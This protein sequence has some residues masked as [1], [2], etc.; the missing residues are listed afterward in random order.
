MLPLVLALALTPSP[1]PALPSV[2]GLRRPMPVAAD[3][4]E[5][6]RWSLTELGQAVVVVE[7][8]YA[9]PLPKVAT[10][11]RFLDGNLRLFSVRGINP[12]DIPAAPWMDTGTIR[13][14][15]NVVQKTYPIGW[16]Y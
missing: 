14:G 7:G 8:E 3:V 13:S 2:A 6:V 5:Y 16:G 15:G 12:A 11:I 10:G 1:G 4:A 9:A